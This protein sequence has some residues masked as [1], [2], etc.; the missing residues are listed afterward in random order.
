MV[1]APIMDGL[2]KILSVFYELSPASINTGRFVVQIFIMFW[3]VLIFYGAR[4]LITRHPAINILRG[5]LIGAASLLFFVAIKYMPI[6]DAIS[7]FFVEPFI[8]M[9]LSA[10]FLGEVI[11]WRRQMAAVVAFAGALLVIQPSYQL[12]GLV[13]LLPLGTALLFSIYLILTR[14]FGQDDEPL[15]MQL[16]SGVGGTII[17]LV[18][19]TFGTMA[20]I[21]DFSL[22]MP[23]QW[24]EWLVIFAIGVL[25]SISH[26]L[27][28]I[29]FR[30]APATILAPFQY[31]EIISATLFGLL[32][33][34]NFPDALKWTGIVIIVGSGLYLFMRERGLEK[35]QIRM[36]ERV[37]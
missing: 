23:D 11:G 18:I 17:C 22:E 14:Y 8:V 24:I 20:G 19:M 37:P 31:I 2:A 7:I 6:A 27:I 4:S 34:G 35:G 12:F 13:S 1:V 36:V 15:T 26:L 29:A 9:L 10:V 3:I 16:Y 33:F 28:V 30:M 32:V 5:F 25:A 21:D